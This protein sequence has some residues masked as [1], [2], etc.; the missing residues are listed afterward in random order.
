MRANTILGILALS[1][2]LFAA[3]GDGFRRERGNEETNALKDALEGK[4]PP[5]IVA[6]EWLN[7]K[8][9]PPTWEKL[10][11]KVVILEFWAQW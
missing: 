3:Q 5:P 4:A 9:D 8:G 6:T 2:A 1:V 11:G 7:W 10:K